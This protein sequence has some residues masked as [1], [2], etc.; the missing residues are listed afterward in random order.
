MDSLP[1]RDLLVVAALL[2]WGTFDVVT[3]RLGGPLPGA[4][5]AMLLLSLPLAVRRVYPLTMLCTSGAGL[6]LVLRQDSTGADADSVA[7]C[8]LIALYSCGA[9]GRGWRA[10]AGV[11]GAAVFAAV[12]LATNGDPAIGGGD[13][14]FFEAVAVFPWLTGY[15]ISRQRARTGAAALRAARAEA[16]R[17]AV[18]EEERRRIAR[19]L[20]DVVAHAI[21]VIVVQARGG[22]RVLDD[23]PDQT[24]E[25]FGHIERTGS[26]ALTEMRRLL[27]VLRSPSQPDM[28]PQPSISELSRLAAQVSSSGLPVEVRIEGAPIDLPPGVDLSAYRIVQEALTNALKHA[29]PAR[30]LVMVRYTDDDLELE[31]RDDGAGGGSAAG[32]VGGLAGVRERVAV[33]G[34]EMESGPQDQGGYLLRVRLPLG[35][36]T[37]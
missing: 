35:T 24:A 25:A 12:A 19:E 1:R 26:E 37:R 16:E 22:R 5:V 7:I 15:A 30:A 31:I 32:A 28:A 18:I 3:H 33:F 8:A 17:L 34:G 27:S 10:W 21:S 36:L 6:A 14:V 13:Y 11:A 9:H 29:G 20:H 4:I 23:H 2:I